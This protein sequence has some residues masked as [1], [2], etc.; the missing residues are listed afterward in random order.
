[1]SCYQRTLKHDKTGGAM[2]GKWDDSI[3]VVQIHCLI[4]L[5]EFVPVLHHKFV[6]SICSTNCCYLMF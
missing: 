4:L 1:M 2:R 3:L 5:Y 6:F